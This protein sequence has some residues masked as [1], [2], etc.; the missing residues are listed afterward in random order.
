MRVS[1]RF[2]TLSEILVI[3]RDQ[4]TRYGGAFGVRD[5]GLVSSATA[6]PQAS[7]GGKYLNEDIFE[8]AAAY[9]YS[10]CQNHPFIDGNKRVG[11]AAALVF[12][13]LNGIEI[14]DPDKQL[15]PAMMRVAS[16][17]GS[18][19]EIAQ[20]L[21]RLATDARPLRPGETPGPS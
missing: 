10:I 19:A 15:Y 4:I 1:P 3:L 14:T 13:D 16:G 7:Y 11:L 2:L 6:A 20:L 9:A 12:L 21:R 5:M 18:K 8:M 17:R